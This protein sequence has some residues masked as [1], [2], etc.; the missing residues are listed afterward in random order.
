[1]RVGQNSTGETTDRLRHE[2]D[3]GVTGEKVAAPDPAMAPLGTD[4]EAAGTPPSAAA[5]AESRRFE[6]RHVSTHTEQNR[7]G[8]A[9]ILIA[10]VVVFAMAIIAGALAL[11]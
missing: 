1:M 3:S 5:I 11:V 6:T 4:D 10:F 7:L 2:I 8:S 9:W